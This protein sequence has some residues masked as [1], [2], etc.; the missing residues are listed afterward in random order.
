MDNGSVKSQAW[1]VECAA[2]LTREFRKNPKNIKRLLQAAKEPSI[3]GILAKRSLQKRI[4]E[5]ILDKKVACRIKEC[6]CS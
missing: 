4:E 5:N 1:S 6:L 3:R 2:K